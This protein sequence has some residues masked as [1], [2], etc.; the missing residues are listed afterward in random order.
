MKGYLGGTMRKEALSRYVELTQWIRELSAPSIA[1]ISSAEEYRMNLLRSF[2]RI[3]ELAKMNEN[4]LN[5]YIYP[6]LDPN[7]EL[8]TD[9][10]EAIREFC[11]LLMDPTKME[12]VDLPMI[13]LQS[14]NY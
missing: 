8:N 3:G 9:D 7:M 5:E 12:N 1:D 6:L 10:I 2:M 14:K 11:S 13:Y 4:I